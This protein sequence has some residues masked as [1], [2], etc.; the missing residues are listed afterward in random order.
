MKK[1]ILVLAIMLMAAA[2]GVCE[3]FPDFDAE[4]KIQAEQGNA[5]AQTSLGLC[6]YLGEIV[7]QN[8]EQAVYWF[9]KAAEQGN[10]DAQTLL[11][12]CYSAGEGTPKDNEQAVYWWQKAAEQ[13]NVVAQNNLAAY[14]YNGN[15]VPVD[16]VKAYM[17]AFIAN[18]FAGDDAYQNHVSA[19][20]LQSLTNNITPAQIAEGQRLANE[21]LKAFQAKQNN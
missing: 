15:G 19:F 2:S 5:E 16:Y 13:G 11:A 21:W 3:E 20:L 10:V 17:W 12:S 8:R 7:P 1:L 14:C 9:T 18:A 6:Y 4:L